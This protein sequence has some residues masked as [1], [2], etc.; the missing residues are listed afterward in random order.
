MN[1]FLATAHKATRS[2]KVEKKKKQ[3]MDLQLMKKIA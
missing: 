3:K 1:Y 2:A